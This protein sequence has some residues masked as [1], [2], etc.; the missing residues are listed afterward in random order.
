MVDNTDA[1][2]A[3]TTTTFL[4]YP[5]LGLFMGKLFESLILQTLYAQKQNPCAFLSV[6]RLG[7][8]IKTYIDVEYQLF[9]C[10]F[11]ISAC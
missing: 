2:Q 11:V 8:R 6:E 7:F 1:Y 3:A 9:I 4:I 10:I 5:Y